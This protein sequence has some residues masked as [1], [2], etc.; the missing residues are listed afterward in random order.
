MIDPVRP[1]YANPPA[2]HRRPTFAYAPADSSAPPLV[3]I[4]T[5]FHNTGAVFHETA[6]CVLGQSLQQWEWVIVN[7]GTSNPEALAV[8]DRYRDL[9]PRIRIIDLPH[10]AGVSAARNHGFAAARAPYVLQVDSDDL[11]EPTTAEKYWWFLESHPDYAFVKGYTVGFGAQE[12][13]ATN[14]FHDRTLFLEQ[15][16]VDVMAMVRTAVHAAVGGYDQ[17]NRG[18]LEDWEFWL[19]CAHAGYWGATIPEYLDWYRRR[20]DHGQTWSN[21]DGGRAQTDFLVRMRKR[22]ASLWEDGFPA[23]AAPHHVPNA[24]LPDAS[25]GDNRLTKSGRR[26]L[27]ICPWL[28]VGGADKFNLDLVTQLKAKG[29]DITIATTVAGD[30]SWLPQFTRHAGCIRAAPIPAAARLPS[31]SEVPHRLPTARRRAR[32]QQ[33]ARLHV[34]AVSAGV[35]AGG[36][37]CRLH[38][39]GG[40]VLE[41]RGVSPSVH[42][43]PALPRCE[44]HP[45]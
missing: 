19:A 45:V 38:P 30:H 14:G 41:E 35:C 1:D 34:V 25:P 3:A 37:L 4:V 24:P 39:H 32:F 9:D 36:D 43:V 22:Y 17:Q 6:R 44:H 7:D 2:S 11:I 42:R 15:N 29:W 40:G 8:L 13:L 18:G 20:A 23:V 26:L 10:T 33:R 27:L 5:P 21:W 12:Y 31:V 28:T 16:P